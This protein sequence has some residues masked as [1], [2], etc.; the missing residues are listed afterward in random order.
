[1]CGIGWGINCDC[2]RIFFYGDMDFV[3]VLLSVVV[4]VFVFTTV[5]YSV[6]L[7]DYD[8]VVNGHMLSC[9]CSLTVN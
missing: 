3:D 1:M 6:G 2:Y 8:V 7:G 5:S 9:I 4:Y